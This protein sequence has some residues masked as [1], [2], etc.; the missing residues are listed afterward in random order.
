[1]LSDELRTAP[2]EN[3]VFCHDRDS[4][5]RAIIAIH[6]MTLG[7]ALG[8]V[9]MRPYSSYDEAVRE[10]M[11]LSSAMTLKAALAGLDL[12]GGKSVIVGDP[13]RDKSEELLRAMGRFVQTL[14]GRYIAGIDSGTSQDDLRLMARETAHVSCIG[15]DP[16]PAT[17]TGVHAAIVSGMKFRNGSGDLVGRRVAI[18]GVGHVGAA[19]AR[20]LAADGAELVISDV[21]G[22]AAAALADEIGARLAEPDEIASVP[23]D[24]FAPCALGGAI[25]DASLKT[26]DTRLVAGA[27]NNVLAE[28]RHGLDLHRRGILYA[29]DFCAN[30]GGI[31]FLIEELQ[32]R[33]RSARTRIRTIGDTLARVWLRSRENNVP[34]EAVA[35]AMAM[36]RIEAATAKPGCS[37][38]RGSPHSGTAPCLAWSSRSTP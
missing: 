8:G 37:R 24:V 25:N 31:I 36:E 9:R 1:M 28:P 17:A 3:V 15:E 10:V 7:P 33:A 12:G 26:L 5:L 14:G 16:S 23:C 35:E 22:Q 19:L 27:A 32:G 2:H 6:D 13:N 30:A 18:Q 29:P 21:R 38:W 4:G 34:P 11:E 20:M